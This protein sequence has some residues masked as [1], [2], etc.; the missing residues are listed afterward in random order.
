[1]DILLP[2]TNE[3]YSFIQIPISFYGE[4]FSD[5]FTLKN[6]KTVSE[7]LLGKRY[8]KF[9][10]ELFT[11]YP[12]WLDKPLGEFLS[13]LKQNNVELYKRF[14]NR[15]GDETYINFKISDSRYFNEKG[16]YA[17]SI[18]GEIRYIGRCRDSLKNRI[19]NGYGRI[20][21]KNCYIDGQ[22]TNCHLNSLIAKDNDKVTLW[23]HKMEDST[24]IVNLEKLLI[25]TLNP[26]WNLTNS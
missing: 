26:K 16:I 9:T 3:L 15:Y 1:M 10:D 13:S 24:D 8:L 17:Y 25:K 23:F 4:K 7:T 18:N 21:P 6:N 22:S 11:N 5:I 12:E 14:L 2:D 20:T 19:N